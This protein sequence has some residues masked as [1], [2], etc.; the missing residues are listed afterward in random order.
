MTFD[1]FKDEMDET[2]LEIYAT[3]IYCTLLITCVII[4][5]F[6][7]SL[8]IQTESVTIST[9]SLSTFE[10]LYETYSETLKC[11]CSEIAVSYTDMFTVSDPIYHQ[12]NF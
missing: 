11:P 6:Y 9:P 2:L 1:F 8:T 3:Y 12:V 4:I 5:A 7:S 10:T